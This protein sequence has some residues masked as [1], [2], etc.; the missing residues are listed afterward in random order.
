V[1]LVAE[2]I[3]PEIGEDVLAEFGLDGITFSI[4]DATCFEA[5]PV[6]SAS[7]L[8]CAPICV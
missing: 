1:T 3:E 4:F 2:P 5:R 8:S 6:E 7:A